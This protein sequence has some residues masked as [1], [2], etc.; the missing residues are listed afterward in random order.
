MSG[1]ALGPIVLAGGRGA[2]LF[3]V[4]DNRYV[5]LAAGFGSVLVGHGNGAVLRAAH[6]QLDRLALGLGDLYPNETKIRLVERLAALHPDPGARVLVCQSGADAITA[7]LKTAALAT[8]RPGVL[9]FERAY[10]GLGYAPLAACGF[11][12]SY[13]APFAAQLNPH[14][15]FAPYPASE[16]DGER[17]LDVA[18]EAFAKGSIGALLIEP[19]LGRGGVIAPV[20]HFVVELAALAHAHGAVVIADEIW[21]GLGRSGRMS[22]M[23]AAA[24]ADLSCF[25]KG[26]G[27]SLGI[28]ACVGTSEVMEAWASEGEV[29]HT[30]T[31]A[32]APLACAAALATLD[33]LERLDLPGRAH[34][35]G[36]AFV[37]ELGD[38]LAPCSTVVQVRG[39]GL[40]VGVELESGAMGLKA[41]R[42]LLSK[43]FVATSGGHEHE[44]VVFTPPLTIATAQ[45]T[46]AAVAL[47][48]VLGKKSA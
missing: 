1:E 48:T 7:A 9:A 19:I 34:T 44:V 46:A 26:L 15:V 37:K 30:S 4:D 39:S 18:R 47:A 23:P 29:V 13:R 21:T 14:V 6:E 42:G 24:K 22:A 41:L 33:E 25:G 3:D 32:G 20:E 36:S 38:A 11:K 28:S 45:L 5:D 40:M 2:N 16:L 10:H 8:G 31:H 27:G 43:G 12:P 17:A 35:V